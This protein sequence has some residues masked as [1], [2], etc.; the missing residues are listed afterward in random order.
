M[1]RQYIGNRY[2]QGERVKMHER[3]R[4]PAESQSVAVRR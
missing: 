2:G 3:R 1:L 4:R